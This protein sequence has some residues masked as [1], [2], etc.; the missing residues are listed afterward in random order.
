[1]IKTGSSKSAAVRARLNHPVIDCDGHMIEFEPDILDY[2]GQVGGPQIVDQYVSA[3]AGSKLFGGDHLSYE[4]RRDKRVARAP[5]W[6][7]PTKN[8]LDRA[9]ATLPKLLYERLDEFGID[10][11]VL[12]PP[13]G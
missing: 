7:V 8:T 9:T 1:M 3:I 2:L 4:E 6:G 5:W 13:S 11:T 12:F 10:F